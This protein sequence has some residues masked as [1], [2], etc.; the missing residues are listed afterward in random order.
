MPNLTPTANLY[1]NIN[2]FGG[3]FES[4][5]S[6]G[7]GSQARW[8]RQESR[9]LSSGQWRPAQLLLA[10]TLNT[11]PSPAP[12]PSPAH[13]L[14]VIKLQ[15]STATMAEGEINIDNIIQRLL[16]GKML[17]ENNADE[18]PSYI[19]CDRGFVSHTF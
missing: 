19:Y 1:L 16:E 13:P 7:P 14:V 3:Y 9:N 17:H 11:S 4:F 15:F 5:V 8:G 18:V 10:A 2:L 6:A 12:A